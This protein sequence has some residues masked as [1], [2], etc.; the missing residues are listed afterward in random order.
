[1]SL[2]G[3]EEEVKEPKLSQNSILFKRYIEADERWNSDENLQE[4]IIK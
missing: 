2:S 1:M 3:Y 4:W